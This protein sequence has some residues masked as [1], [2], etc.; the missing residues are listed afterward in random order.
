MKL[1]YDLNRKAEHADISERAVDLRGLLDAVRMIRR[2][3]TSGEA[4][5]MT[6]TDKSFDSYERKLIHD[7]IAA[8][9]PEDLKAEDVFA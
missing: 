6:I 7:V 9:I 3:L 4:L 2:G 8:R 1:F 5:E